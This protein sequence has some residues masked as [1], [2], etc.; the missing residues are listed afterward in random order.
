L[1]AAAKWCDAIYVFDTGSDDESWDQVEKIAAKY[2]QVVPFKRE[3][4]D[5]DDGLRA[6]VFAAFR[7][8]ASAGDWWC[9]LDADEIYAEDPREFL[10]KVPLC[11]HVVWSIHLQYY[12][13]E[14][15]RERHERG[16]VSLPR[17]YKAN[18][19]EPRFFRHR[20]RL[21]WSRGAW[22]RHLGIVHPSRIK[23]KHYQYRSPEQIQRRLD[24]RREAATAGWEHFGH[25][26]EPSWR[27]KVVP[28][29][30][31]DFDDGS[32]HYLIDET[33]LPQHL[34]PPFR[35]LVKRAMHGLGIWP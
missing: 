32:D 3:A 35:R 11:H 16:E 18:A 30:G 20:D 2:P 13:T 4:R 21:V 5:F 34:E 6:E 10:E 28:A 1:E 19:S 15:D 25:S 9:R 31:L 23:L 12:F 26:L 33:Q 8:R 7:D 29:E 14:G 22:P 17:F 24:T 27:D